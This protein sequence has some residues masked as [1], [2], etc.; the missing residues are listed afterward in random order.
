MLVK[1]NTMNLSE[2]SEDKKLFSGMLVKENTINF[3]LF[4]I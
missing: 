1:E 4:I 3:I 2:Y